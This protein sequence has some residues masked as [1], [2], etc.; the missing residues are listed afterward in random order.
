[1]HF[2]S[3]WQDTSVLSPLLILFFQVP[4]VFVYVSASPGPLNNYCM[5]FFTAMVFPMVKTCIQLVVSTGMLESGE[6]Q[7]EM[8]AD[9]YN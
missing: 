2:P 4:I 6:R 5:L 9:T 7:L 8:G 3:I 1:M